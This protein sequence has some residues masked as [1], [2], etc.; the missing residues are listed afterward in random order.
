[1]A[2][3]RLELIKRHNPVLNKID[4]KSPLT[5]GNG[6]L[7]FTAD[8]T[9]M[10]TLYDTYEELP[11]CTMS[12]WGWH[13]KPVSDTQYAYT[14]D[15][16]VMTEYDCMGRT[17]SYP[18]TKK[19]GNEEVYDWLRHNPHRFNL[20]RITLLYEGKEID[21]SSITSI[22][23]ELSLYEGIIESEFL[24]ENISC[25]VTTACDPQKDC[26]AFEV[27]SELLKLGK[28]SIGI[29]FPYGAYDI[30]GS[31]WKNTTAH[32]ITEVEADQ[33]RIQVKHKLDEDE[34]FIAITKDGEGDIKRS[35][36]EIFIT[37]KVNQLDTFSFTVEFSQ[38]MITEFMSAFEVFSS[39]KSWWM[40]YWEKGG[41]VKLNKSKD[42]RAVE[43]ERRIILSQYLMAINSAG[44]NPP[45]ET[46]LTC[47][48]WYG[49]MHLEMYLWH[50]AWLPLWNQ[51]ELL[52]RSLSW[53][54]NHLE[55][56][57]ENAA[58][59]GYKGVRWPKMIA[60]EGIDS[61]SPIAP[62]LVWQQPHIIFMLE[63]AYQQNKSEEFLNKYWVLI[64]ETAE[65]MIDFV[66]Y[67]KETGY[68]D[69][70][71]PV[72]PVQE[73]H[74]PEETK[75]PAF[76]VEYW[77]ITLRI[78]TTWA[79]RLKK[80]GNENWNVVAEHMAPMAVKDGLYLSHELCP[81]TYAKYNKDHPL[82]TGS[83]GLLNGRVDPKIMRDTLHKIIEC[84]KYQT[85]WGW[86]FAMMAMTA[87][88]LSEPETAIE[89]LLMDTMKNRFV[90]SG[91]NWQESRPDLP[92]YLP[93]NGAL[94]LAIPLMTAG[95]KG[96]TEE[97]PGFP[98]D[99]NWIVE[100][101]NIEQY[102]E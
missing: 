88:R 39:S 45:Q 40:G 2:I 21:T 93:G 36:H 29:K 50:C 57:R 99:G 31:D 11:L 3:N 51:S 32:T 35:E 85:L 34:Y 6:E 23:Q 28:L 27:S 87:V 56:A 44:S 26:L 38:H 70:P 69:I 82:M 7:G 72:I 80:D 102:F 75:N 4:T 97:T 77:N 84:W 68:Y 46:G 16:L 100:Y 43:L 78:A 13:T 83:F 48:S 52:E 71:S 101:E 58:R 17:V 19:P 49:K 59:N 24:L 92:L 94:L 15:D 62:L 74:K 67:N 86:D 5:V 30:T 95:Y 47:N 90:A 25:H 33:N 81:E 54:L 65:F 37:P 60:L 89:I 79:K 66:H 64:E 98:K 63:L 22:R 20:A 42:P 76:E 91:N 73:C 18:K 9:G 41:I 53:Y 12:Q 1:M 55:E 61:P 10:Q 14:L 8:I 96:C